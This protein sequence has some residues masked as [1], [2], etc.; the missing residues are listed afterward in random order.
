MNRVKG[1]TL[2]EVLIASVIIFMAIGVTSVVYRQT[3]DSNI[4]FGQL[5]SLSSHLPSIRNEIMELLRGEPGLTSGEGTFDTFTFKWEVLSVQEKNSRAWE[6]QSAAELR[7]NGYY[8]L[9]LYDV[10]VEVF[11]DMPNNQQQLFR[12]LNIKLLDWKAA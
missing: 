8:T 1:L 11:R 2:I 9:M 12:S 10:R 7:A 5:Y 4:R 3:I 6:R